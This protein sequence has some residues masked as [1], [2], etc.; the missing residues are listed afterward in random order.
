LR[1]NLICIIA[2]L[3][4]ITPLSP[5]KDWID[6]TPWAME[7]YKRLKPVSAP[8]RPR[9]MLAPRLGE[10]REFF[11]LDLR[12]GR[13]YITSATLRGIGKHCYI[14]V[15][16]RQWNRTVTLLTVELLKKAFDGRIYEIVTN[17]FGIPPDIDGDPRI[18]ILL[19]D[20]PDVNLPGGEYISGYFSPVNEEKGTL[21]DPHYGVFLTSNEAEM[22]YLDCNPQN[23]YS[24]TARSTLA[25]EFQH[26]IHWKND[27][28]EETWVNEGCSMLASFLCGYGDQMKN[29][30]RAFERNPSTSLVSWPRGGESLL[31]SYGAAYLWMLY[32]YEHCGGITA[33]RAIAQNKLN[34]IEG[35]ESALSSLGIHRSFDELFSD[36]KVTNLIDDRS[37]ERGRYG[38]AHIDIHARPFKVIRGYPAELRG[39]RLNAY[40]SDYI[41]L[42]PSR[43][44]RLNLLF[45]M[46]K[47]E[48]P[49]VRIV[50][51]RDDKAESV[52][53]MRING[54]TGVGRTVVDRFGSSYSHVVLAVSFPS[55]DS[56]YGV[57]ARF[58][59]EIRFSVIAVPNPIHG[60]YWEVIAIPSEN[61]GADA[62]YLRLM[63]K[64]RKV[65]SDLKMKPTSKGKIFTASLFIPNH[66][67]PGELTWQ[68]FFLGE[69]IGEGGFH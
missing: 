19:L 18:Y 21:F 2:V 3:T 10:R 61:P 55:G 59:G 4:L 11:A 25:H 14:F 30:V 17:A 35:V 58:G 49:D 5:G 53:R 22:I 27:E 8:T 68:V 6:G 37:L 40:A 48:D 24:D 60:R 65:G 23:P 33:V 38:Y 66:I 20:I 43:E 32:I 12:K 54:E 57:S 42:D 51:L 44:G 15:E 1:R 26:L 52:E 63:F 29:H 67:D 46:A 31:A 13:Q 28:D 9:P 7:I 45:E 16:D 69:K 39:R 56:E 36:W 64:G 62:P 41:Q 34:G 47:G 50:I